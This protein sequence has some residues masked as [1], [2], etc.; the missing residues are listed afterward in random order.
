MSL[1]VSETAATGA[2]TGDVASDG[3]SMAATAK[4]RRIVVVGGGISGLSVAWHLQKIAQKISSPL[5]V[6]VL[7]ASQRWGGKIR[8]ETV[9]PSAVGIDPAPA[10]HQPFVVEAG[11]DSFLTQKPWALQLARELGLSDRLIGTNDQK[12]KIYVLSKGRPVVMPDGVLMIVPTK[13]MPFALSPLITPWGKLRMGMDLVLPR[14]GD[15]GDETLADF[16][17]RRLGNEALDKIAEPLMSGI[18]NADADKQSLLATFPRFRQIEKDHRSLCI[19]MIA[20]RRKSTGAHKP[21]PSADGKPA[22]RVSAFMSLR[23]G[24]QELIDVLVTRLEADLRLNTRVDSM[25]RVDAGDGSAGGWV[26]RTADAISGEPREE[27]TADAIVLTTPAFV[28]ARLLQ[29][30]CPGAADLLATVRHV[31]TGTITLAYREEEIPPILDGH[32]VVVPK[33]EKRPINAITISS[34]KFESRAPQGYVLLR[35]FFGGSRSP[36]SM[37]LD[38]ETLFATVR[39]ELKMIL[40]IEAE[41]IFHRIYRWMNANP[42]Y[43]VGHLDRVAAIEAALPA[44]L[45]VT[46]AA[47]RGVGMPDCV[48]QAELT[49]TRLVE[50]LPVATEM[51]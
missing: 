16:V 14:K 20:S 50:Q 49:A 38:D 28:S 13:F 43:D 12:R 30:T 48:Y 9:D 11:P 45:Y 35:A 42:Q 8:T 3:S 1:T 33:S 51:I 2:A 36:E 29:P 21:R 5:E 19:G 47:F 31:S 15:D 44:G 4:P 25:A 17:R 22:P 41:P 32:G 18:Y 23:G 34:S 46:G 27:I 39:R 24:S 26:V 7:E 37:A 40:D 6:I 10:G